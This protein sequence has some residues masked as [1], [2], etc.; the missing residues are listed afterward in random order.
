LQEPYNKPKQ[1]PE[2]SIRR[3]ERSKRSANPGD[4]EVYTSVDTKTN[5]IY[6]SEDIDAE[7]DPTTYE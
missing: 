6:V 1:E 4:Y 3:S 7:G 2:P 5:E